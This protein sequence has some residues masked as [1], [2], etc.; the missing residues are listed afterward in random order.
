MGFYGKTTCTSSLEAEIWAIFRGLNII[1]EKQ[2]A[3]VQIESDLLTAVNLIQEVNPA[4]HPQTIIIN[5]ANY[6]MCRTSSPVE[7]IYRIA[8]QSADARMGAE[9][10]DAL[11]SSWILLS[12]LGVCYQG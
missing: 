8:N 4:G 11:W 7:H 9:Q 3:N 6:L 1:L 5:E 2:L 10:D 12:L